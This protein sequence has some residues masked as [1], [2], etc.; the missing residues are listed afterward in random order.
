MLSPLFNEKDPAVTK[1]FKM[2][3]DT[4]HRINTYMSICGQAPSDFP[5]VA[6]FLIEN[7]IDAI[8]LNPDSVISFLMHEAGK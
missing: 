3:L 4:A 5:E 2:A 1:M 6:D 7:G 8:S